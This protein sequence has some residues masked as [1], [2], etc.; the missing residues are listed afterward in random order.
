MV[1]LILSAGKTILFIVMFFA[2]SRTFALLGSEIKIVKLSEDPWPPYTFGIKGTPT[3]GVAVDWSKE[4]FRR[5]NM[6]VDMKLY[7]WKRCLFQMQTG[8]RDGL[9]ALTK[10]TKREKYMVFTVP[11]MVSRNFVWHSPEKFKRKWGTSFKWDTL[12]DFKKYKIGRTLG[13]SYGDEFYA[14]EKKFKYDILSARSDEAN[15]KR[16]LVGR[17][18]IFICNEGSAAELFRLHPEFK[19]KLVPAG[20]VFEKVNFYMAFS[21]KSKIVKLVPQI[22]K[23]IAEMQKDGTIRAILKKYGFKN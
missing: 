3:G 17:I 13:F 4:I 2:C 7:P 22:N 15:F 16:L 14:A 20:K 5:L 12:A 1:K 21:K 23:I 8:K 18:D 6:E 11:I 19:G 9:M 10:N